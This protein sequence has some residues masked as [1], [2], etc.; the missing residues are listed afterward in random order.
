MSLKFRWEN[1]FQ[2]TELEDIPS[3]WN[4]TTLGNRNFFEI[5]P[6]GVDKFEEVKDYL[7]TSSVQGIDIV[8]I[9]SIITYK[10]RPSRANMQPIKNSVW[11]ARMIN[12]LKVLK[13]D[14]ELIKNKILSTGFLG[15]KVNKEYSPD[16][17]FYFLQTNQF[18]E[19]KDTG[20]V[21][22]GI[23]ESLT[24]DSAIKLL[25]PVFDKSEQSSIGIV[26]SWLD[27]LIRNKQKQCEILENVAM[28]LFKNWFVY[29]QPFKNKKFV[30]SELWD[31]P[32][33]W[34]LKPI[35]KIAN[36]TN[37]F[38]YSG[39]EKF[40]EQIEGSYVFITLNN[41]IEGGGFKTKYF[42]I[43]SD[44]LKEKHFLYEGDLIIANVHFGVGGS[45]IER[46]LATPSIIIFPFDYKYK[47]G[48]YSMDITKISPLNNNYKFYLYLYLVLT[49]EDSSSFSTG[50]SILHL[51]LNNF[52]KNKL[53]IDPPQPVLE[54]FNDLVEPLFKKITLNKKQIMVLKKVR[55]A[56]LP[57][58]VFGK[59]RVEEL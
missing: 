11:F 36:L 30:K 59:L 29:F 7:S 35:A 44:R 17:L 24:N 49:R 3:D 23:Q 43:Q 45:E 8:D 14:E 52:K 9:Q 20:H 2:K 13:A 31:I 53:I 27:N 6:S 4:L 12:S 34:E 22:G 21:T 26:L 51:D 15:I 42:W 58:L 57:L 40:D 47:K 1:N 46:L 18:Q 32:Q 28:T 19:H 41:V 25:V 37:G 39:K 54:K 10:K 33:D 48:V 5:L 16:Y 55:D 56:L 50:T 38:S